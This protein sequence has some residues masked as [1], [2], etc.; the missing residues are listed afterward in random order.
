MPDIVK[1]QFSE[2]TTKGTRGRLCRLLCNLCDHNLMFDK[3]INNLLKNEHRKE[4]AFI[5]TVFV[6]LQLV[7]LLFFC[8]LPK[9]IFLIMTTWND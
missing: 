5:S 9:F 4:Y 7:H 3:M 2:G 1:I 8:I 6:D